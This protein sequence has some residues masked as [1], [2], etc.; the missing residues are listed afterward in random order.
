MGGAGKKKK[1]E[2]AGAATF[3]GNPHQIHLYPTYP[4]SLIRLFRGPQRWFPVTS[5][6]VA[7]AGAKR[8]TTCAN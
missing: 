3:R 6:E 7:A 5:K 2:H 1:K 4:R 8:S